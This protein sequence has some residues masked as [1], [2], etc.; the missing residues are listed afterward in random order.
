MNSEKGYIQDLLGYLMWAMLILLTL[1]IAILF[2][3]IGDNDHFSKQTNA[4]LS[5][6]GGC[7]P[8]ALAEIENYSNEF[9]SGRYKLTECN[10]PSV[11][12]GSLITYKIE[13]KY[14]LMFIEMPF[15]L[16]FGG[17]ATVI[18]RVY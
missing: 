11:Q 10:S 3:Q 12:Y 2:K 18:K 1:S 9:Y 16:S 15:E 17:S 7:N 8:A 5:R 13:G 4:I 6:T 14:K